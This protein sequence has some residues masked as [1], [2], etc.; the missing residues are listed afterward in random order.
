MRIYSNAERQ[1]CPKYRYRGGGNRLEC[2]RKV[3]AELNAKYNK[4]EEENETDK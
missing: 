2:K 3:Q 4:E 1:K